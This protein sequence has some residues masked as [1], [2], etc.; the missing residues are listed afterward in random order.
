MFKKLFKIPYWYLFAIPLLS[1]GLGTL[2]NQV[3]LWSN[4]DKFPVMY[5]NEKIHQSCQAPDPS[6]AGTDLISIL[7]GH[8][9]PAPV[10]KSVPDIF[11]PMPAKDMDLCQNGG[12]FLDDTHVIMS[13]ESK[14]KWLSDVWD[15]KD[16]TYSIGDFFLMFAD[17]MLQWAPLAW[18]VLVLRRFIE[19]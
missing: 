16:V 15:F 4:F 11:A 18:L 7:T 5:N 6:K 19:E 1:I 13:K 8:K 17:W 12:K 14:L 2:S 9:V 10:A 3:V